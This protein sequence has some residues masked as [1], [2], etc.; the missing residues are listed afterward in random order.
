MR[1]W[2]TSGQ[3]KGLNLLGQIPSTGAGLQLRDITGFSK[4]Q[5]VNKSSTLESCNTILRAIGVGD[6][7]IMEMEAMK[8]T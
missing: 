3:H 6:V 2:L 5:L 8:M 1:C 7:S 4:A